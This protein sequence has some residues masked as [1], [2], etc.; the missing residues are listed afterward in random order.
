MQAMLFP[1][2]SRRQAA[3]AHPQINS[4]PHSG[5]VTARPRSRIKPSFSDQ[6]SHAHHRPQPEERSRGRTGDRDPPVLLARQ[7]VDERGGDPAEGAAEPP[8]ALPPAADA[9]VKGP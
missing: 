6:A 1:A 2:L 4:S 9:G 3:M 5:R 7:A 8:D